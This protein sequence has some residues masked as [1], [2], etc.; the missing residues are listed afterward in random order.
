MK[1]ILYKN[2]NLISIII[3]SDNFEVSSNIY[4]NQFNFFNISNTLNQDFFD[5]L[6]EEIFESDKNGFQLRNIIQELNKIVKL[7]EEKKDFYNKYDDLNFL[8]VSFKIYCDTLYRNQLIIIEDNDVD[9]NILNKNEIESEIDAIIYNQDLHINYYKK[10]V[11]LFKKVEENYSRELLLIENKSKIKLNYS[12]NYYISPLI[13]LQIVKLNKAYYLFNNSEFVLLYNIF[14]LNFYTDELK[15][16]KKQIIRVSYLIKFLVKNVIGD[17]EHWAENIV[18]YLKINYNTY[19]KKNYENDDELTDDLKLYIKNLKLLF[20][21][22]VETYNEPLIT[23]VDKKNK[24][25]II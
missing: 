25:N 20:V 8:K 1:E 2:L 3:N 17:N 14:N 16:N 24:N 21:S 10:F 23:K 11:K 4:L 18:Y 13:V 9:E 7:I 5:K 22:Q 19:D 15:V 6:I 12:D